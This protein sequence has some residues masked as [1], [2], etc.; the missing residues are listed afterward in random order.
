MNKWIK[1][2]CQF[3]MA[4]STPFAV[5]PLPL[6]RA[7]RVKEGSN[8]AEVYTISV[9][10]I[11]VALSE[12]VHA[13]VNCYGIWYGILRKS[14][15]READALFRL[16]QVHDCTDVLP[17]NAVVQASPILQFIDACSYAE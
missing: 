14:R 10:H 2:L 3:T 16:F 4:Q 12:F 7:I 13:N 1:G 5:E 11:P 8:C 9:E 17:E 6:I 15:D